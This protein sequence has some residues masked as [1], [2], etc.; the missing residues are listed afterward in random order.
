MTVF[1]VE[2]AE[3]LHMNF[4]QILTSLFFVLYRAKKNEQTRPKHCRCDIVLK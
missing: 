1:V 2:V 4:G 3:V